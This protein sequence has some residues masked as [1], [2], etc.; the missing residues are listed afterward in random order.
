M[1]SSENIELITESTELVAFD[2]RKLK[3]AVAALVVSVV[4]LSG[5]S[6][7]SI[8]RINEL[9][10]SLEYEIESLNRDIFG[11]ETD[12]LSLDYE[13]EKTNDALERVCDCLLYTSPSPRDRQKS[14]MPSSA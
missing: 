3:M 13:I 12:L 11:L 6:V 9:N 8:M 4:V 5:A 1:S 10:D 7:F 2:R 14:R